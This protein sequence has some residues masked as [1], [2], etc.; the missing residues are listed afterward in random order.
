MID[1]IIMKT[2]KTD[3]EIDIEFGQWLRDV[4]TRCKLTIEEAASRSAIAPERL[5]SLE[6]G[7]AEKGVTGQESKKICVTYRVSLE[8][9]LERAAG[10][11]PAPLK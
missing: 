8:E 7:Y 5:K 10:K 9:F 4:R 6:L 3:H 2:E 11:S 1:A